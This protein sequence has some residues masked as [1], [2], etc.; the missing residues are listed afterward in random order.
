MNL[1]TAFNVLCTAARFEV[2]MV[3]S[4]HIVVIWL[5]HRVILQVVTNISHNSFIIP[6]VPDRD[7]SL[8]LFAH[9][10]GSQKQLPLSCYLCVYNLATS[11][12]QSPQP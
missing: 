10:C 3:V 2:F 7:L 9:P 5:L 1:I 12:T 8:H 11:T 4:V 6:T